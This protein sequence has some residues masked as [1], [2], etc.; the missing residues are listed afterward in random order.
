[1][2]LAL[3]VRPG[4]EVPIYRQLARQVVEAIAQRTLAPGE[5]LPSHREL[6]ISLAIAPLTVKK[7]YDEL[8]AA[9][10]LTSRQ[11]SGTFVADAPTRPP[12]AAARRAPLR[13]SARALLAEA[14]LHGLALDD[15]FDLLRAE[16]ARL[17]EA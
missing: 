13:A 7:A 4:T 17:H 12:T 10:F 1:M 5:R 2:P 9:G 3:T 16:H 11:G 15:L 14:E 8:E 6:A